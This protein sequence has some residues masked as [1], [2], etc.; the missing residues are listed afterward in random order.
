[1]KFG[2]RMSAPVVAEEGEVNLRGL[3]RC[4]DVKLFGALLSSR[5]HLLCLVEV[6]GASVINVVAESRSHHSKGIKIGVVFPQL[7]CLRAKDRKTPPKY[8]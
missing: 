7:A 6:V 4:C 3:L 1:M 5:L 8:L 2:Q